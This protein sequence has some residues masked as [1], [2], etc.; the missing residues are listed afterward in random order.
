MSLNLY[1]NPTRFKDTLKL[2]T[3]NK[4]LPLDLSR[5]ANYLRTDLSDDVEGLELLIARAAEEAERYTGRAMLNGT[6]RYTLSAWPKNAAGYVSRIIELP[7]SPLVSVTSVQYYDDTNTL[8]T[9]STSQYIVATDFEPGCIYLQTDYDWP[10][11]TERPDAVQITF[12]AGSGTKPVDVSP[13][14]RQAMLL[15][16]RAEYAGGNPNTSASPEDDMKAANRILDT[17]K[18]GGWTV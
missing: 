14:L 11:L 15:L 7:R 13:S 2:V 18:A 9:L 4:A 12:V 3:P 6:Y 16:C 8:V 10:E 17:Q 5:V 1:A